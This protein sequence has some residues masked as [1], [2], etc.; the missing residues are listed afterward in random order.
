MKWFVDLS[1]FVKMMVGFGV[2]GVITTVIG[3][4]SVNQLSSLNERIGVVYKRQQAPLAA[5]ADIQYELQAVRQDTLKLFV[6]ISQDE[7]KAVVDHS[8]ALD[9]S[10]TEKIDRNHSATAADAEQTAFVRFKDAFTRYR[11]HREAHIYPPILSGKKT[12]AYD[13]LKVDSKQFEEVLQELKGLARAKQ[14]AGEMEVENAAGS[15]Y[16]TTWM[17]MVV[18]VGAGLLVGQLLGL[19]IAS[20]ISRPL[21]ETVTILEAVA[22]GDLTR[23]V[24]TQRKDE[25]G[26]MNSALNLALQRMGHAIESIGQSAVVLGNSS[27]KLSVVSQ[28]MAENAEQTAMQANVASAAAE[29]VSSNVT[30][31]SAGAEEMGVSIKEIARSAHE[32]AKVANCAVEVAEQ[33][34]ANVAKLGASSAQI[35]NVIKVITSIAQQTNLLALN[36]TIEAA[37]A[38]EAGKGFAVVANE[39]KE[40]AKQTAQATEDIS[41]KIEAIQGDTKGAIDAIAQISTIIHQINSLQHTIACAVEEQTATTGEISRNV[42]EAA[43][44]SNEIAQNIVGVAQAAR[45][46]TE[47]ASNT[48]SSAD[49]LSRMAAELQKLVAQFTC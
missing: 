6:P 24:V 41:L 37:R 34:N 15:V 36:A 44:G 14:T 35:G 16:T 7:C 22:G 4:Y 3:I 27:T 25:I 29:Q 17:T 8:L 31:V 1:T 33:A 18:L 23:R 30:S 46:T 32:A 48:R 19:G 49:D 11:Q 26:R 28:Q 5:L 42:A 21:K 2:L 38:G 9:H 20:M 40:L 12:E 47:G 10:L 45:G 43:Q 39:V 13:A